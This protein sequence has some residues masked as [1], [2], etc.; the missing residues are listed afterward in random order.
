M[1]FILVYN[2]NV[3]LE[4]VENSN[5]GVRRVSVPI[6]KRASIRE[7]RFGLLRFKKLYFKD[8]FTYSKEEFE[9]EFVSRYCV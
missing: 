6:Y 8:V 4:E 3:H 7:I 1:Y 2:E 5:T 9:S